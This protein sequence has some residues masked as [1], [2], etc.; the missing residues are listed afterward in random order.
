MVRICVVFSV[1]RKSPI[2][3]LQSKKHEVTVTPSNS[4]FALFKTVE[5][6]RK[7]NKH[8]YL[9]VILISFARIDALTEQK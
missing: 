9:V 6:N 1:R 5:T 7:K 3:T 2:K 4:R 8:D